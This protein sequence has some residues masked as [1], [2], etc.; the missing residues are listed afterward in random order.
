MVDVGVFHTLWNTPVGRL[1]MGERAIRSM[2]ANDNYRSGW[3][4]LFAASLR[5]CPSCGED[6]EISSDWRN[7][8]PYGSTTTRLVCGVCA[9]SDGVGNRDAVHVDTLGA[10]A[11]DDERFTP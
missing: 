5:R 7:F 9:L 11:W 1:Q 10:C 3:D 6:R 2:T 4:R 8:P